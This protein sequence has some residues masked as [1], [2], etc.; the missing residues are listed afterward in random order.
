MSVAP[1]LSNLNLNLSLNNQLENLLKI[2]QTSPLKDTPHPHFLIIELMQNY[3]DS[4]QF[5]NLMM[6]IDHLRPFNK[7][8]CHFLYLLI[9]LF[10]I[11]FI[12]TFQVR[13]QS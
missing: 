5:I 10:T 2:M 3:S 13:N 6:Y 9:N 12:I 8:L 7:S 1:N 11:I 4:D